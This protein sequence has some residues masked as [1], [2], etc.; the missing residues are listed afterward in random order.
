VELWGH[1]EIGWLRKDAQSRRTAINHPILALFYLLD[2]EGGSA[3]Q[4]GTYC[5]II[6]GTSRKDLKQE[7]WNQRSK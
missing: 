4:H 7:L 5:K 2:K 1:F 3:A 6:N